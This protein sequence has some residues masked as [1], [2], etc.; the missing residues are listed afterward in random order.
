MKTVKQ[1][2][3]GFPQLRTTW[4][5]LA[6]MDPILLYDLLA[7]RQSVFVVEQA[8]IYL[9]PDGLDIAAQHLLVTQN[10]TVIGCL[11]LLPP[12]GQD[13]LLRIGRV[14]VKSGW[15]GK[16]IARLMML[17]AI[18]KARLDYPSANICLNAQTYLQ[19]FYQSLGFE[20]DGNEFLEDGIPHIRMQ[21]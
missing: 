17:E 12:C 9:D 6:E 13:K 4:N 5:G 14:T 10:G 20:V 2:V 7:L 8:C 15:R 3:P 16:G 18:A 19:G 1:K 21:M 11:R